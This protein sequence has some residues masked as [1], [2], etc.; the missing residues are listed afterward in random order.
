MCTA[1]SSQQLG[2]GVFVLSMAG[3]WLGLA[4]V[5]PDIAEAKSEMIPSGGAYGL[6]NSHTG[7]SNALWSLP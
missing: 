3:A 7:R 4:C 5:G 6:C 2:H 1:A